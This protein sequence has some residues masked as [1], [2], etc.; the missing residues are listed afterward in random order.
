MPENGAVNVPDASD[1]LTLL[2]ALC[3][4]AWAAVGLGMELEVHGTARF[5]GVQERF[6]LVEPVPVLHSL[7]R[8]HLEL[9]G[10]A[11]EASLLRDD[12]HRRRTRVGRCGLLER[13]HLLPRDPEVEEPHSRSGPERI[14]GE[15]CWK[16]EHDEDEP[17]RQ[18]RGTRGDSQ[19][20]LTFGAGVRIGHV[21][22]T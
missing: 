5:P 11:V 18:E 22:L 12:Q 15:L 4:A 9:H 16:D 21:A 8:T 3:I 6:A 14:D 20:I 1:R 19:A 13:L 2:V 10:F 7:A 17:R